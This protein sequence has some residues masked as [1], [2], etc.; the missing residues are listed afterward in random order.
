MT[1]LRA[2]L[3]LL[4]LSAAAPGLWATISPSGFFTDFPGVGAWVVELPPFNE[5]LTRDVGAFY[6]AFAVLFAW[7]AWR[8]SRALV[9]PLAISW[10]LFSVL[11][12]A[13]HAANLDG[14]SAGDAIG[15]TGSLVAVL[16]AG[17]AAIVMTPR[18]AVDRGDR[19]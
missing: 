5:H 12:L 2:L 7:A 10:S 1:A 14:Y 17:A 13:F 8:P 3:A 16:A 15:Q 19:I 6:C 4:A 9:V 18:A 11:H